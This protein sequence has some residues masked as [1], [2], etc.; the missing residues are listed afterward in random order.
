MAAAAT[1]T[2]PERTERSSRMTT[3]VVGGLAVGAVLGFAGNFLAGTTQSILWAVSAMGLIVAAV[4]LALR[5]AT[6]HPLAAVGFLLLALGETRVLNPTDVPTGEASFAAGA[7]L[8]APAL[9]LIAASGWSPVW[10]RAAALLAGVVFGAHALAFFA[11]AAVDSAGP[12][13]QIGY[14][15]L[16]IAIAGWVITTIRGSA[17][18]RRLPATR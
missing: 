6:G 15:V 1:L 9:I 2:T 18:L 12:V 10:A 5:L 8:Y 17:A 4:T 7:F 13:A 14:T 16:M 11:G 3:I